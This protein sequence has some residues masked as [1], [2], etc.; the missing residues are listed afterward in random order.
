[1]YRIGV[2]S[3]PLLYTGLLLASAGCSDPE[4]LVVEVMTGQETDTFSLDPAVTRVELRAVG[5]DGAS[6]GNASAAPGG[7]LSLGTLSTETLARF[8]VHGYDVDGELRVRGR[9]LSLVLGG[10]DNGFVP[11]FAQRVERWSR[12]PG[13]LD[14]GHVRGVGGVLGERYLMLIGGEGLGANPA[15][16]AFYDML[17]WGGSQGPVLAFSPESMVISADA[18]A[19]LIIAGERAQW[20]EFDTGAFIDVQPPEGL[21]SFADVS[22][23][24]TVVGPDAAYLVGATREGEATDRVLVVEADRSLRTARLVR[25]RAGA[26]AVWVDGEGLV[27]AGGS[28]ETPGVEVLSYDAEEVILTADPRPFAADEVRGATAVPVNDGGAVWLMCGA[29]AD[30]TAAA[31]R[32]LDLVG[33][34]DSCISTEVSTEPSDLQAC[35]AFATPGGVLLTGETTAGE[36]FG[37]TVAFGITADGQMVQ[38]LPFRERRWGATTVAAPNGTLAVLGGSGGD[39]EPALSVELLFPVED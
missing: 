17:A 27:I 24:R 37:E 21:G 16:I 9:S 26:A 30:G 25:A 18:Q 32:Q 5:N 12:P 20:V 4:T 11:V 19:A 33:C 13:A 39:G 36:S 10:I 38:S 22:G 1:M 3:L 34:I 23:G 14:H 8:E 29:A 28:A 15:Q 2:R 7:E 35:N 31:V 6:L